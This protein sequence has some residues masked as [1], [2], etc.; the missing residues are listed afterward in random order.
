MDELDK[1]IKGYFEKE[2]ANFIKNDRFEET[3]TAEDFYEFVC[4]N[5]KGAELEKILRYLRNNPEAQSLV[6]QARILIAEG[7]GSDQKNPPS[8]WMKQ[9]KNL[10]PKS[11]IIQCPYCKKPITSFKKPIKTQNLY[12]LLW[13]LLS[14]VAFL[15]SFVYRKYFFQCLALALFFGIKWA[16]DQKST[17]T[18]ILIYKALK[19]EDTSGHSRDLH[20]TPTHL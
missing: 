5:M 1:Q 9:V 16:V 20:N 6:A 8:E 11:S 7:G 13:L 14:A 19:D 3:P 18:Q 10:F 15:S 12:N 17:K 2:M 4:D